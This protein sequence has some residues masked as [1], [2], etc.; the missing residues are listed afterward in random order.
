MMFLCGQSN[1]I[2]HYWAGKYPGSVGLLISPSYRKK[3]PIDP[4]MPFALDND[5]Y[6][7]WSQN[8]PWDEQCWKDML[9]EVRMRRL[10]PLWCAVPDVVGDRLG[11][12]RKWKQYSGIV[13]DFG[14]P[15]AFCVQDGMTPID[16]PAE[17][18]VVFV[19]GTDGWKY[20]NLGVW[21]SNFCR[22]HCARVHGTKMFEACDR[23]NC[24]SIDG[25]GWFRCAPEHLP[26]IQRFIEGHRTC[27]DHLELAF[28]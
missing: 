10:T 17:A 18:E 7:S 14:W 27:N 4:W 2:W 21:T 5:A 25:S 16:V 3:V 8:K 26:Q 22:V 28:Q 12:L 9:N 19:G 24:E 1:R 6:T 23:L 11:T 13:L 15:V 20:P